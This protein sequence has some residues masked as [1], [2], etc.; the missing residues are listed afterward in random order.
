MNSQLTS[1]E[2]LKRACGYRAAELVDNGMVVGLGSG[3]TARYATLRIAQR[4]REGSLQDIIAVPTS[5]ATAQL[6]LTEGIPLS[7]LDEHEQIDLTIDGADEV[8]PQLNVIKGL[9]GFLLREKIVAFATAYEVIVVDDSKLVHCLG[10]KSP[11]PV[12]VIRFGW[13]HTRRALESTGA[14]TSLR[15]LGSEPYI[16]D[17]G[18][19]II[20]CRY[21]AIR[22]PDALSQELNAIPGVVDNGLFLGMVDMVIVASAKG[23]QILE[24][25][26]WQG[27]R[28]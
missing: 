26:T 13:Q 3:T 21:E 14:Q 2:D 19:Y 6:A 15:M 28:S 12:E 23:V 25:R 8:D 11:L 7:E 20:D 27:K 16:T 10:T 17:E 5:N 1:V 18:N 9:G 24:R 4:L 22:E